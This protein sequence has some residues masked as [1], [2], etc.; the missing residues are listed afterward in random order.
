M[1][2][3]TSAIAREWQLGAPVVGMCTNLQGSWLGIA[4]GDGRLAML[5]AEEFPDNPKFVALHEGVA[6]SLAPDADGAGFLTGGDDG[7]VC[8]IEPSSDA[9]T[10]LAEHKGKWIDHVAA[11]GK[12]G[13]RAY[14]IGKE[15][16]L[17]DAEGKQ[18]GAPLPHPSS[19]G[20]LAFTP[21]GKRI[22]ASHYNGVSLWW[23]HAREQQPNV[24]AWKGSH[25]GI[26]WHPEGK[27]VM[28]TMQEGA[29]HGWRLSDM[30]EMRMAGYAGKVRSMAWTAKSKYLASSGAGVPV[31]WPFTGGGPWGKPPLTPGS[32]RPALVTQVAP[33]PRDEMLAAGY[34]DGAAALLPLDGRSIDVMIAPAVEGGA[35]AGLAWNGDGDCLF[36]AREDGTLMLFTL[37]SVGRAVKGGKP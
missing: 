2:A 29:L 31:C 10:I 22:A 36:A 24:L 8:V 7:R 11:S 21:K 3:A 35:I 4:L 18:A 9:P 17:L 33:H 32:E 23:T 25:L 12:E 14:A 5:K 19:I 34:A 30:N 1:G 20:G 13:L 6:L 16:F 27:I 15:L 26:L 37:Q 28:T